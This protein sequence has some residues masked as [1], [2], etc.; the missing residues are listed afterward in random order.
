MA[1]KRLLENRMGLIGLAVI[2]ANILVAVLAPWIATHDP[3]K[4]DII[5][6]GSPPSKE[7]FFGTDDYGRDIFS[8][9]LYGSRISLYIS[10]LSVLLATV[11][12]V[13]IG[14]I[15]GYYGGLTDNIIMRFMDAIMSF[16]AILLA[17][18]IMAVLGGHLYN[19]VIALGFVYIPRFARIIRG[20]VLSLKEKEFVEA[21]L[22]MGHSDLVIIFNHILPNCTAPLIV[23]ATVSLA[24]AILAEAAL[25]FLGLGAPPPAPSWGN[26]LS[27]ARNFMLDAPW[28]TVFPGISITL[29]VLGFNLFGDALRDVLDPRLK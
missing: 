8:R 11:F 14:A 22:A 21:S 26:I 7:F 13:T 4:V 20:S 12:G 9:V 18:G 10:F 2:L 27:D 5:N 3:L 19:V 15:A 24:Y 1:W 23:Q 6:R 29:A 17:I 25:S 28:M 16:P